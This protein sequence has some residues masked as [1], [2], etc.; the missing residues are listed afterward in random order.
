MF[1]N[2]S[3]GAVGIH[4]LTLSQLITLARQHGFGGIDAPLDEI[5]AMLDPTLA[6][7]DLHEAGLAW[8]GFGLPVDFRK[9]EPTYQ[10]GMHVLRELAPL[11][12]QIGCTRCCT[13][14]MPGHDELDY[15]ANF[16]QHAQRLKPVAALLA[17][18]G[19]RFGIEFVGPKTL[20]DRFKHYFIHTLD[21]A[22]ELADAISPASGPM[23]GVLLDAFHWHCAG[24]SADDIVNKLGNQ[25][26]VYVHVNDA[27]RGRS[28]EQQVDSE[29]ALPGET[30]VI[31]A[32]GFIGA[33]KRA[34]YDGPVAAEPFMK[35]L[36][37]QPLDQV[38]ARVSTS[39]RTMLAQG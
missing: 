18:H 8:G 31:D 11:A 15:Q 29:R 4:G 5:K 16:K 19:V 9:D 10:Q 35:E 38:A 28:R 22:L 30:G 12:Q 21:H 14:I 2:L 3:P 36:A 6:T 39:I 1:S 7:R 13:W 24:A 25:R 32:A 37:D 20:R 33:L 26:I 34:N 23:A 27:R 17:D